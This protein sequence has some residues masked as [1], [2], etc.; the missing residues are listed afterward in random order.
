MKLKYSLLLVS[1]V[2]SITGDNQNAATGI[3]L[4]ALCEKSGVHVAVGKN[5]KRLP[6][7]GRGGPRIVFIAGAVTAQTLLDAVEKVYQRGM[8]P[9]VVV[10]A[11][12][13]DEEESDRL[14]AALKL[15]NEKS[16]Q[17]AHAGEVPSLLG[18]NW[19]DLYTYR[20]AK[21]DTTSSVAIFL[22]GGKKILVIKRKHNPDAGKWSL[23]GGFLLCQLETVDECGAREAGEETHVIVSPDEL[24]L[25]DVRSG[26]RRDSRQQVVDH[27]YAW[28]VPAHREH[29]IY[30]NM[31]AA[32]D[33]ESLEIVETDWLLTQDI[34]FDH[35]LIINRA[36]AM[37][38]C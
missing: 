10:D 13:T 7:L 37:N 15:L 3:E 23:P 18:Q 31:L 4:A 28:F 17:L 20:F 6:P 16:F 35:R 38:A 8:K 29:E 12:V 9:I 36:R 25:V 34:A 22:E 5:T 14:W 21:A 32:D 26:P 2:A 1:T 11:L 33:A 24:V 27:G 19:S 30:A